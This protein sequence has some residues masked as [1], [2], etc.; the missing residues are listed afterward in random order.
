M[1]PAMFWM[2]VAVPASYGD[3]F[4][5]DV[6]SRHESRSTYCRIEHWPRDFCCIWEIHRM[7][8]NEKHTFS[9]LLFL[10]VLSLNNFMM[11]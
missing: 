6:G 10:D 8:S 11:G 3:D 7:Y 9:L 4:V 1:V 2:A 5:V